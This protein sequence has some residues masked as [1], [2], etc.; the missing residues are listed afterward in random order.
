M[1]HNPRFLLTPLVASLTIFSPLATAQVVLNETASFEEIDPIHYFG[2]SI[3]ASDGILAVGDI[4]LSHAGSYTGVVH[5]FDTESGNFLRT[6]VPTSSTQIMNAGRAIAIDGQTVV[7]NDRGRDFS[8]GYQ[9]PSVFVF[10][11]Q[12]GQRFEV[13]PDPDDFSENYFGLSVDVKDGVVAIGSARANASDEVGYE[14]GKVYLI[15]EITGARLGTVET[16]VESEFL[17]MFGTAVDIHNGKIA[18]SA[19]QFPLGALLGGN[20]ERVEIFDLATQQHLR[21]INSPAVALDKAGFGFDIAMNDQYLVVSAPWEDHTG[22]NTGAV[23][24]YDIDTGNLVSTLDL[25]ATP[26]PGNENL[27][28]D[29]Q[30][31][32]NDD[33]LI[34]V[35]HTGRT[36]STIKSALYEASSGVELAILEPSSGQIRIDGSS[37]AVALTDRSAFVGHPRYN[38]DDPAAS[39]LSVVFRYDSNVNIA[40]QPQSLVVESDGKELNMDVVAPGATAYQWY[41]DGTAISE[42]DPNYPLGSTQSVLVMQSGPAL[43]GVYTVEVFDGPFSITSEPAY[44]LYR[45]ES[46]P[47]C[48]P[49]FNNDGELDFFDV[50]RFIQEFSEGCP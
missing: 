24:V 31:D 1:S 40:V 4:L 27:S 26:E 44:F 30:V 49:D 17:G 47:V 15:D 35:C 20:T 36:E 28:I 48:P 2:Y 10:D 19:N 6:L 43:E 29:I 9:N 3:G 11:A 12:G 23:H 22:A 32:I 25:G 18:V 16:T 38:T 13:T 21:T 37:H 42:L 50:S 41:K 46:A 39:A 45:G 8:T 34:L 5:L 7:M 14:T 33:G